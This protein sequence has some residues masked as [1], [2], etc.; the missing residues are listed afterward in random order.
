MVESN[1]D[2]Q[3]KWREKQRQSGKRRYT[4]WLRRRATQQLEGLVQRSGGSQEMVVEKALQAM[5]REEA[6]RQSADTDPAFKRLW[7]AW[8]K[9]PETVRQAFLQQIGDEDA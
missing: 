1:R 4:L 8:K 7:S 6:A 3:R 5:A 9:A 2:R